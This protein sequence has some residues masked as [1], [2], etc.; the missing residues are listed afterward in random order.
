MYLCFSPLLVRKLSCKME[1][2]NEIWKLTI[3]E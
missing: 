1:N 3:G 2:G